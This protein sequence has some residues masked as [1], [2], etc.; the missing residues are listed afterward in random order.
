MKPYIV[1]I[2]EEVDVSIRDAF[3]YIH[4]R[5]PQNAK[6]WLRELYKAIDS[7]ESMPERCPLIREND[8]FEGTDVRNLIHYSHRFIF[9]VNDDT[10]IVEV[11]AFRH[12]AQNDLLPEA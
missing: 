7:L 11:H 2:T 6:T 12:G 10:S 5:S 8:A 1:N 4:E 9:T 3:A